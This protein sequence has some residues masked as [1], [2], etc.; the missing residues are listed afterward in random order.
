MNNI[1]FKILMLKG[2]AGEPTDEQTQS[3]VDDYMQAHPEA[4]IDE[5]IINSAV[6]DWLDDHP[7]A[8]T[9]VQDGSLTEAKLS[10]ALKL[11]TIKDY[12]TPE[13]FG[14]KGDGITNDYNAI[15]SAIE[16]GKNV[17]FSNGA[18]Y[19]VTITGSE[20]SYNPSGILIQDNQII[21]L[22]GATIQE[23]SSGGSN[24]KLFLLENI[25][26][27]VI[28]NGTLIG[29]MDTPT[30]EYWAGINVLSS[31]N[32]VLENLIIKDF[33][34]DGI[35]LSEY[36]TSEIPTENVVIRNC[37]IDGSYR[38][39][40]SLIA[41]NNVD[42]GGCIISNTSGTSPQSGIDIEPNRAYQTCNEI[43]IHDCFF[44]QNASSG[45]AID[46]HNSPSE[47][48]VM[49]SNCTFKGGQRPF[50]IRDNSN[51]TTTTGFIKINNCI[52][53][54]ITDRLI[55]VYGHYNDKFPVYFDNI[56]AINCTVDS[57]SSVQNKS[58]IYVH[59]DDLDG[60]NITQGL[61]FNNIDF[62]NCDYERDIFALQ[63][64]LI[65]RG[66]LKKAIVL[67]GSNNYECDV[68]PID[69]AGYGSLGNSTTL[70]LVSNLS[71]RMGYY[72]SSSR[73]SNAN[74]TIG[75]LPKG[76]QIE[77]VNYNATYSIVINSS[78]TVPP[79]SR[80]VWD[81]TNNVLIV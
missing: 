73:T 21:D 33:H 22:N 11:K 6:G 53:D 26:N 23:V 18:T 32:I 10:Q 7:E 75:S 41:V 39:G 72:A 63:T 42:I 77:F 74:V 68:K 37:F 44:E 57:S 30:T 45:I 5:T 69:M 9:T 46:Y 47:I 24:G 71:F 17:L 49:I 61:Y 2:D 16:T 31:N 13:M 3:A 62:E 12:V 50:R 34:G 48:S 35:T 14:A 25:E 59:N 1:L 51:E 28:K 81:T 58:M 56:K 52:C 79:L 55:E 36:S 64:N 8:T 40:I 29:D 78:F 43:F 76:L 20:D 54:G 70:P 19:S 4:A 60:S 65:Y 38:N 66:S 67:S 27:A 80:A 15:V